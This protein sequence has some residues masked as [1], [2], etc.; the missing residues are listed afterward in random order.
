MLVSGGVV[1]PVVTI[2]ALLA[3]GL[4]AGQS[5]RTPPAA[6][7]YT[8]D[9]IAHQWR[10][11]IKY[12]DREGAVL[13][14]ENVIHIPAGQTVALRI[15]SADVIHSFWVPRLGGKIDAIPGR[16]NVLYLQA[17]EPGEYA[18]VC[19]EFCG[20]GH[21]EMP[22]TVVAHDAANLAAARAELTVQTETGVTP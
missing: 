5:M 20:I 4:P 18:G 15:G 22:M 10:W 14:S 11:E 17:D 13:S 9:V 21:A 7:V 19:A 3:Y 1:L 8:V 12:P 2:V 6:P 16:T